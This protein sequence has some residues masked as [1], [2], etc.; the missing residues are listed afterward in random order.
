VEALTQTCPSD[1]PSGGPFR[2]ASWPQLTPGEVRFRARGTTSFT[3]AAGDP[4]VARAIDPVAGDGACART[5]AAD[6]A[7]TANWRL[8]AATGDGYTLLGAPTVIAD[9]TTTGTFPVVA[10]RLWDVA[11]DGTQSLVARG[12]Y[13]PDEQGRQVFQ[14]HA[15]GWRFAPGH[16]AKLQLLG[17]DAPY[18]R[19]SNG[20]FEVEVK[21]VDVR[22]PVREAIGT[23]APPFVPA[24]RRLAPGFGAAAPSVAPGPAARRKRV[25]LRLR[26]SCRRG[27]KIARVR[28][29]AVRRVRRVRFTRAGMR[30][31]V[32]RSRPFRVRLRGQGRRVR[33]KAVLRG[34]RKVTLRARVR[35]CRG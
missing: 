3:S 1:A 33:A 31:R 6:E 28:G 14:L 23:P 19:T 11:P 26:T 10:A 24:G 5:D 30:R 22:L 21:D 32:D 35:R 18:A 25:R 9:I 12:I 2:A 27:R 17:R 7:G 16:V 29:R 34:G 15:N 4:E 13:R 20:Q 8:P